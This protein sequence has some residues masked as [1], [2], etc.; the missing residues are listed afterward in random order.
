MKENELKE[1]RKRKEIVF[2]VIYFFKI[3][4]NEMKYC[5]LRATFRS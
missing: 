1:K 2:K 3:Y 4:L 5:V